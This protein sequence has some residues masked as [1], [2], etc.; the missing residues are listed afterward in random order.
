MERASAPR[1]G[2]CRASSTIS[3]T[4]IFAT[5]RVCGR[6]V[7]PHDIVALEPVSQWEG[8]LGCRPAVGTPE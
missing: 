1:G 5:P 6:R 4:T 2:T 3:P 8:E 7:R